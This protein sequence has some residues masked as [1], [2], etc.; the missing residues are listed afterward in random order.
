MSTLYRPQR[1]DPGRGK[2]LYATLLIVCIFLLDLASGGRLRAV[3]R[4][5]GGYVEQGIF[6]ITRGISES[7]V[8]ATQHQLAAENASLH[9]ALAQ[10]Q[11]RDSA[12]TALQQENDRLRA[13]VSFASTHPGITA[14]VVSS[15]SASPYGTFTIG[16]GINEGVARDSLVYSDDGYV[17]GV[18]A[19][20]AA[21]TALVKQLFAPG[22]DVEVVVGDVAFSVSGSGGGNAAGKAPREAVI[23][24]GDIA[25]GKATG[26]PVGV[27]GKV[28]S[29]AA[30]SFVQVYV[31]VPRNLSTI[32]LVYVERK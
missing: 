25:R 32:A 20:S 7:G 4:V 17:L 9:E 14:S 10:F 22:S 29:D 23:K 26:A 30:S 27:V 21:H 8:F 19:E 31:R 3:V 28:I 2:L 6:A 18:V 13:L 12:Y 1:S 15:I 24:E 5:M 11:A 16:A